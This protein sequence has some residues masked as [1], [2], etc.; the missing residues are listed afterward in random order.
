VSNESDAITIL[1]KL[2]A[3]QSLNDVEE[4]VFRLSWRGLA[5][6][7]IAECLGY[8]H[9]YIRGVGFQLWRSLSEV[10][11]KRVTKKNFKSV[12]EQRLQ[13]F[14]DPVMT[15]KLSS[16]PVSQRY[17][18]LSNSL[19][20]ADFYG[21][22]TERATL[23]QWI[24]EDAAQL[25]GIFGLAGAGKTRLAIATAQVLKNQFDHIIWYPL[26]SAPS[27]KTLL[28]DLVNHFSDD[29]LF[30]QGD[31][32]SNLDNDVFLILRYF[33]QRRCLLVLDQAEAILKRHSP[34]G[35]YR[36]GHETYGEFFKHIGELVH[37]SCVIVTS[38]ETPFEFS[39]LAGDILPIRSL[40]LG[41]LDV[42]A[43]RSI[44]EL[45]G[46]FSATPD[47]WEEFVNVYCGNPL[48]LKIAGAAIQDVFAGDI[49]K[50]LSHSVL[51]FDDIVRLLD[52]QFE[53]LS[54][55]E[56]QLI[57]WFA[58]QPDLVTIDN[59]EVALNQD[60]TLK[61]IPKRNALEALK[62]LLRRMLVSKQGSQFSQ[63]NLL[64]EYLKDRQARLDP[65]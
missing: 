40:S 36:S 13:Q 54:N 15:N 41:E 8:D 57:T 39:H 33:Q 52:E 9:G 47:I 28:E 23:Y 29:D 63:S 11:G 45:K 30:A 31:L 14:P 6:P 46:N 62:S 12:F 56:R 64:K 38:R 3:E 7:Q 26:G 60:P 49:K 5:Y 50:F 24:V 59:L 25:I 42:D 65:N 17:E 51:L 22:E 4:A 19:N 53:R 10:C 44:V 55:G 35:Q 37:Q 61:A 16:Q 21:R 32:S 43:C 58:T 20:E 2:L 48:M 34:C 1:R 27:L 18:R